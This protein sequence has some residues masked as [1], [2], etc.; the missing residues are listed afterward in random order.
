[1]NKQSEKKGWQDRIIPLK[2]QK[3]L[4]PTPKKFYLKICYGGF[5]PSHLDDEFAVE[6]IFPDKKK[7]GLIVGVRIWERERLYSRKHYLIWTVIPC[8]WLIGRTRT[9]TFTD[10]IFYFHLPLHGFIKL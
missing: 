3:L 7:V 6:V 9:A 2:I 4:N 1:M 10:V 5:L 8:L